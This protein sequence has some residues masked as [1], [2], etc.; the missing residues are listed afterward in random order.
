MDVSLNKG[1]AVVKLKP[2]NAATV[3]QFWE[4]VRKNGFTTKATRVVVR[5][6]VLGST[7]KL[8]FKVSGTNRAYD[9]V[10]EPKA[11]EEA[12]RTAGKTITAE[13]N[14]TPGKESG[15]EPFELRTIQQ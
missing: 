1:L 15:H 7:S 6:D 13:G 10:A 4:A 14:L 3:E 11:L 2:G 12:K 5:G 9:L 8:Q